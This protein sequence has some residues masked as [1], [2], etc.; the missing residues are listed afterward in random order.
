MN[1]SIAIQ[2]D[3]A[4]IHDIVFNLQVVKKLYITFK[5]QKRN[6][7]FVSGM[8]SIIRNASKMDYNY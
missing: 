8:F 1:Q 6:I 2:V 3:L 7:C 4:L 5:I